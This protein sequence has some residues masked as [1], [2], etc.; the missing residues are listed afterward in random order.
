MPSISM[1]VPMGAWLIRAGRREQWCL[2][3]G[4]AGGGFPEVEDLT[5][6]TTR[7]AVHAAV[8]TAYP[9][10]TTHRQ[11]GLSAQLH[12]LRNRVVPGDLVALPLKARGHLAL[13]RV[14]GAYAH[15]E[16][17][18]GAPGHV[19]RVEWQ[20]TDLARAAVHPYLLHCLNTL[21]TVGELARPDAASRLEHLMESGTDP[22]PRTLDEP[23]QAV[24]L[25]DATTD[26][27]RAHVAEAFP[28]P[29][30]AA[31]V[32]EV[33]TAE[34]FACSPATNG[35]DLVAGHGPLG[36]DAPRLVVQV[37]PGTEP[38]GSGV[39]SQLL[40]LRSG[41]QADQALLVAWGGL[42]RQARTM[43]DAQRFVL[44]VW[45]APAFLDALLHAY[46]RLPA[47]VRSRMPLRQTW[48]LLEDPAS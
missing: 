31:L 16:T 21:V 20:R 1:E 14:A 4:V 12:A 42:S 40:G 33:L 35:L 25:L 30:L 43:A 29:A 9:A 19:V 38:A 27:I 28:G 34:G 24:D 5:K 23:T 36:L 47:E 15:V 8:V 17:E 32:A 44:R 10:V 3:N 2:A 6:A 48:V 39:V 11:I 18:T 46:P 13:G 26:R 22:G 45:D 37:K 41:L 7:D